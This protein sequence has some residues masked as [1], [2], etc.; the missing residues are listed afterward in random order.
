MRHSIGLMV[1]RFQPLTKVHTEIINQMS[2]ENDTGIVF[3]VKS[4]KPSDRNPFNEDIQRKLLDEVLPSNVMVV[5]LKSGFFVD[6]I[7]ELNDT[8]FVLYAGTDRAESYT[9]FSSYMN[10]GKHLSIKEINRTDDDVSATLVRESLKNNNYEAF[11]NLTDNRT[12]KYFNELKSLQ[13]ETMSGDIAPFTKPV[14][15]KIEKRPSFKEFMK[16]KKDS[17]EPA[18]KNQDD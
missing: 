11:M 18:I 7:N 8:E 9:K 14:D 16:K 5:T 3:L 13:E 10:D 2:N 17:S 4:G 6:Y 1:G 15:S 12:H